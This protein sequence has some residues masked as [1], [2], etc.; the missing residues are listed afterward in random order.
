MWNCWCGPFSL[1]I[2]SKQCA[3]HDVSLCLLWIFMKL[4]WRSHLALHTSVWIVDL[5]EIGL[6]T[7]NPPLNLSSFKEDNIQLNVS[8]HEPRIT[9]VHFCVNHTPLLEAGLSQ[10]WYPGIFVRFRQSSIIHL[11]LLSHISFVAVLR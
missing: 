1:P 4:F 9:F 10:Y 6:A 3:R 11:S 5:H 8:T 7:A 2:I